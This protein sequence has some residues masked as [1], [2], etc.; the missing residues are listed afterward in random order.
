M[1][2]LI[3]TR[4][5]PVYFNELMLFLDSHIKHC[6]NKSVIY[7]EAGHF[8]AGIGAD[9]FAFKFKTGADTY[10]YQFH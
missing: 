7:L 6:D 3:G 4:P 2:P 1:S 8:N 10:H 5:S 9:D